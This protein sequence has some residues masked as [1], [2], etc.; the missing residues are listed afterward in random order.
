M[1]KSSGKQR[2]TQ[3]KE[4]LTTVKSTNKSKPAKKQNYGRK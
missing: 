1:G 4:W 2:Y 3:L